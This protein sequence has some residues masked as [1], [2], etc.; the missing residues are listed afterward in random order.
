MTGLY[1]FVLDRGFVVIGEASFCKTMPL[2][3]T[4]ENSAT[5]RRWGTTNGLSELQNGPIE[6]LTVLDEVCTRTTPFRAIIDIIH[7][8]PK[9]EKA[10]REKLGIT[11]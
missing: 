1:I 10:W 9:G 4:L 8:T 3:F 11:K 6:G 2:F 5:I 7:L